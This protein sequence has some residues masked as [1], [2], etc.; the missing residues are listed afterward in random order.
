MRLGAWSLK[1]SHPLGVAPSALQQLCLHPPLP[2]DR[3][4]RKLDDSFPPSTGDLLDPGQLDPLQFGWPLV[5]AL[6][7]GEHGAGFHTRPGHC[8]QRFPAPPACLLDGFAP[9]AVSFAIVLPAGISF[10]TFE[11]IRYSVDVYRGEIK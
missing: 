3:A 7:D 2:A 1:E 9:L 4:A 6:D 8:P 10:Y 5:P 11:T